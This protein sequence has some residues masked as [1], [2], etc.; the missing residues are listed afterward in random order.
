MLPYGSELP[1]VSAIKI[2]P[3]ARLDITQATSQNGYK[4]IIRVSSMDGSEEKIYTVTFV[5]DTNVSSTNGCGSIGFGG[6]G[7]SGLLLIMLV[8]FAGIL[9][10]MY[11]IKKSCR[12][13][14]M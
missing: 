2:D 8:S 1:V 5:F 9:L 14:A 7:N 4:A 6:G 12:Q 11:V 3:T 13:S 10:F